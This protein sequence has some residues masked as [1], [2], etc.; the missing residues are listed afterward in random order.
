MISFSLLFTRKNK[1]SA[2]DDRISVYPYEGSHSIFEV[3]YR[4]PDLTRDRRFLASF[5]GTLQYVEDI[6][7]SMRVD[8]DPFEQIQLSTAIHPSVMFHVVDLEDSFSRDVIMN[9]VGDS[10]RFEVTSQARE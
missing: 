3:V 7:M 10:M 4:T 5:S 9:M 2:H 8:V 1:S 6:L